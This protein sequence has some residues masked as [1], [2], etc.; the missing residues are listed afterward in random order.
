MAKKKKDTEEVKPAKRSFASVAAG[1]LLLGMIFLPTTLLLF[2]M[3]L[4]TAIA[5]IVDKDRPRAL[6]TT[7]GATNFAGA[8]SVWFELIRR[9]HTINAAQDLATN[10]DSLVIAYG[11]AI[12]GLLVYAIIVPMVAKITSH[13][14]EYEK[15]KIQKK[16]DKM[17]ETWGRDILPQDGNEE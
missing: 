17:L 5:G 14:A 7:V 6:T 15:N 4:P 9:G 2:T 12:I 10:I 13:A 11:A 3:M 1:P 8:M 16:Q